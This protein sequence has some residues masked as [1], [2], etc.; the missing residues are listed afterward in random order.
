M[1]MRTGVSDIGETDLAT[2]IG[3]L[4]VHNHLCLIYET[5]EEQF[6]A[7]IP[8]MR[9]GLERG[10]KCVYIVD[11][12]T[13]EMVIREMKAAGIDVDTAVRSGKLDILR[14]Q[15]A[16]LKQGY[17]DPDWMISFLKR[18]TDEAKAAG[19]SALRAT[20]EMTWM[21]GGDPGTER[22]IEYEAK[23]NYFLPQN[24]VLA[25]CQY[26]RSRFSPEI[27]KDVIYTHPL[28]IFGGVV[29]RNF[30][31]VPPDEFLGKEQAAREIDRLL[32]NIMDREK[33]EKER[34][35][36][37]RWEEGVNLLQ[38]SLLMP[39]GQEQKL[40]SITDGIVRIFNADF[41]RIWL[42]SPGDLCEQGCVH[43]RMQEEP[44]VCRYRDRCLHLMAS[45]G[46][47]THID[48]EV[49]RRV[50]FGCY[51]IGRI[52][53]G[54]AHKFLTNDVQND[55]RVHN[56]EW[57]RD[58]G[59]ASFAGYQ[60]RVP[61]GRR[62]GVLALFA[63]H[64]ISAAEDSMLDGLSNTLALVIQQTAA[65]DSL[66][67]FRTLI[68]QSNDA[69]EVIDP[70][71]QH[72]LD[73]NERAFQDLGFSREE[74]LSMKVSDIDPDLDQ[75]MWNRRGGEMLKTGF[76]LFESRHRR[77]D[78]SIFPVEINAKR[79]Q[80]DRVYI[81]NVVRDI[82][83]RRKAEQERESLTLELKQKTRDL[84]Q[85]LYAGSHDLK[86]PLVNVQ[87]YCGELE[88]AMGELLFYIKNGNIPEDIKGKVSS[89]I[90][91]EIPEDLNFIRSNISKMDM[92]LN[93]L[94]K[95]SRLGRVELKVEEIDMN[96]FVSGIISVFD[97]KIKESGIKVEIS[98]IP[99][100]QSDR[101]QLSHVFLNLIGNAIKYMSPG[102][103]GLIKVSGHMEGGRT[104]YC[105]EDNGIG[106]AP[107][108]KE[109]IFEIFYRLE[110]DRYEGEGLG[111]TITRKILERLHGRIWVE[112]E[113]GKGSRFYVEL[114]G[115]K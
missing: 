77:K 95:V 109:K 7:V 68:D 52:A 22:L 75:A 5:R 16:Y 89:L 35:D 9:I 29:C 80:L 39:A 105:V 3:Q 24:D 71:T 103:K 58:L 98:E 99:P 96:E 82:T 78:G 94:M 59:L 41:C 66:R 47:Y 76:S 56:H 18:A 53:S 2:A 104:A 36:M 31:Y 8:F 14:K 46:R 84:E 15:D 54:E 32:D 27:I 61:D 112:S 42:I 6:A 17:F 63:K 83:E 23:L 67:L 114:P 91:A 48:G 30:Y 45:S 92:L 73:A 87:G 60:L 81:V 90:Q 33:A 38:Q 51:K 72:F 65:E 110:P 100:C 85:I 40:K 79:V 21:L 11:D 86:T 64:R 62:I 4:V 111:L 55:P 107:E 43:A 97:M 102:R 34:D 115:N 20:G 19:F 13:A 70:E 106:I 93:G 44:H 28:I 25:I 12:N 50:P 74:L 49:H 108:H 1:D 101:E 88:A 37:L 113:V 57:A 69:I 26:N 10:E